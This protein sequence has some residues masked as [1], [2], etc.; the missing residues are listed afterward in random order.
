MNEFDDAVRI[1][2]LPQLNYIENA[3][4]TEDVITF[5]PQLTNITVIPTEECVK[6]NIEDI[7]ILLSPDN[8]WAFFEI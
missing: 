8:P 1:E 3:I 5:S 2:I 4:P 7:N 6:I